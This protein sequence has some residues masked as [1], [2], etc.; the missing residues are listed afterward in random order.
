M[1]TSATA[2][3]SAS[4]PPAALRRFG[5]FTLVQLLGKSRRTMV[6]RVRDPHAVQPRLLVLPRSVPA[7]GEGVDRWLQRVGRAAR[8][9]H[10][11]LAVPIEVAHH[12]GWPYVT[13]ASDDLPLLAEQVDQQG[14]A[15]DA[16]AALAV[17]LLEALAFAHD[18]EVVHRDLQLFSILV[19]DK[20]APRLLGL[21][22]A[23]I[24]AAG[25][26]EADAHGRIGLRAAAQADVLQAGVLMHHMLVGRPALDE[27]DA[28]KVVER[29]PPLGREVL[30][31]PFTTPRPVPEPLRA[32][33]NRAVDRQERQRYH[34][35]RTLSRALEGWLRAEGEKDGGPLHIVQERI[36]AAGVLP[37]SP[38]G[39]ERAA[40][41][42]L[43]ERGRTDE[44]AEVLLEDVGLAFELLRAV[45]TAQVRGG[46]VSGNG[47]VLTVRR[48]IAM[49][50]LDGVRRVALALRP[51]P[52]PLSAQGAE[53]LARA[54]DRARRAARMATVIRPAGYD[55]EVV[56]LVAL[57][58][59]LG[60]LI[61]QYHLPDEAVQIGRLMMPAPTEDGLGTEPGMS[62]QMAS[63]A[64]LGADIESIGVAVAR[65]WGLDDTV[66]HMMRRHSLGAMVR[67]PENDADQLRVAASCAN[68]AIDALAL[69]AT[70]VLGGLQTVV[71]R[72]GRVL[73][74]TL[75]DLQAAIQPGATAPA[76]PAS[77]P[78]TARPRPVERRSNP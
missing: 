14:L 50:G 59:N 7:V 63:M 57:L 76:S 23:G 41:L 65:W 10:P 39:A 3:P 46:Q 43:M 72:Y 56:Y 36:R 1:A 25:A 64:V 22:V 30:R 24:D 38:G 62:E 31:L 55:A 13:Y 37:S 4:S 6:W 20:G 18:A 69:P 53:N 35:A 78:P 2:P 15:P 26:D 17:G 54:L 8:L 34:N 52:G 40:R 74:L 27:P 5:R 21:E 75:R 16:C 61:V 32:I 60:R 66:V 51:W 44:L 68:E 47:V 12:E 9:D 58:Q 11:L 49:I 19:T 67:T 28:R 29:L 48:S 73:G 33:V 77:D 70:R 42:G 71:Q 45:N